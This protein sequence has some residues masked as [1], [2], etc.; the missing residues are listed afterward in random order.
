MPISKPPHAATTNQRRRAERAENKPI[1]STA[2]PVAA[3]PLTNEQLL[4]QAPPG[5]NAG[6]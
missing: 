6:T 2:K 5:R 3:W 1:A 4:S